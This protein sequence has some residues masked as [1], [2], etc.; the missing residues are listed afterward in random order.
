MGFQETFNTRVVPAADRA[1]GLPITIQRGLN[2]TDPITAQW[3][4]QRYDVADEDGMFTAFHAR[5]FMFAVADCAFAGDLFEPRAGCVI[6]VTENDAE[7]VFEVCPVG[8]MPAVQ[9]EPGG[10]RWRVHSKRVQ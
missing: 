2:V 9:L 10:Y 6:R 4:D 8:D 5:D 7:K 1:F 3:E